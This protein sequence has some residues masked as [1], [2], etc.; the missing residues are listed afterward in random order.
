MLPALQNARMGMISN[1]VNRVLHKKL[2]FCAYIVSK[3]V[4]LTHISR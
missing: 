3:T 4:E 1:N 2:H